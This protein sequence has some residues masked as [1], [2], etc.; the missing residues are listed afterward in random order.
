[1]IAAKSADAVRFA[2][3]SKENTKTYFVYNPNRYQGNHEVLLIHATNPVNIAHAYYYT[4][5]GLTHPQRSVIN[6]RYRTSQYAGTV[7]DG[8]TN[9][10]TPNVL[11]ETTGKV[12]TLVDNGNETSP[13]SGIH[14]Y[15]GMIM[16]SIWLEGSD[17]D[18]FMAI[19]N[20]TLKVQLSFLGAAV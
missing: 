7:T 1:V 20:D 8:Y 19:Y 17:P 13:Y 18:C 12:L 2:S 3:V 9:A 4:S 16:C 15:D 5:T 10:S 6:D 11:D 14:Y